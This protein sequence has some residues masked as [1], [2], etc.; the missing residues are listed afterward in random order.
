[1]VILVFYKHLLV[2][3]SKILEFKQDA[4]KEGYLT[5]RRYNKLTTSSL[6]EVNLRPLRASLIEML[7]ETKGGRATKNSLTKCSS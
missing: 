4:G 3:S 1:M 5:S 6:E 2:S 7:K